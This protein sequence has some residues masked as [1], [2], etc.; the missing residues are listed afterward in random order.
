[1]LPCHDRD[2]PSVFHGHK[3]VL[4]LVETFFHMT[5]G[6]NKKNGKIRRCYSGTIPNSL[7]LTPNTKGPWTLP[8]H[9]YRLSQTMTYVVH[10]KILSEIHNV[11][12]TIMQFVIYC[13]RGAPKTAQEQKT[14]ISSLGILHTS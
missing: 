14:T 2:T 11:F 10:D 3:Q 12:E 8:D 9:V 7:R 6:S 5:G 4:A 1:V 13:T